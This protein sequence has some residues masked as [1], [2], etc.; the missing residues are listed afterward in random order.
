MLDKL[1][2]R[3]R[4]FV[5]KI[6]EDRKN[7]NK[8]NETD[9]AIIASN[10]FSCYKGVTVLKTAFKSSFSFGFIGLSKK[11]QDINTIKHEYGHRLQLEK[12]GFFR[13]LFRVACPSVTI[14]I[15]ARMKK[16]PY[17]YYSYPW[18]KEADELGGVLG[19]RC[20]AP[21][22]PEDGYKSY[23]GLIKLFFKKRSK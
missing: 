16:L 22:L 12:M 14:N 7:Y 21:T 9:R 17:D 2:K 1:T 15:L 8:A 19:R 18:E 23:F 10:Y 4:S 3:I 20:T 13:Y 11:H 6:K 5:A